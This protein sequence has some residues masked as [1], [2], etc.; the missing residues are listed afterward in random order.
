MKFIVSSSLNDNTVKEKLRVDLMRIFREEIKVTIIDEKSEEIGKSFDDLVDDIF[1]NFQYKQ[2]E[3]KADENDDF[4]NISL[5][6]ETIDDSKKFKP[7]DKK[8]DIA[9]NID[10][11]KNLV[12]NLNLS[13]FDKDLHVNRYNIYK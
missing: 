6:N 2:N 7:K 3:D 12:N 5:F 11:G 8:E 10:Y 4:S 13:Y 9:N 1:D